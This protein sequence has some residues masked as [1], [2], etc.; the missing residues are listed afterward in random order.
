MKSVKN[1][2]EIKPYLIL[3][4]AIKAIQDRVEKYIKIFNNQK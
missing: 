2:K 3:P 4:E 1:T